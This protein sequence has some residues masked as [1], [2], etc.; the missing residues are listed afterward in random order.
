L[1]PENLG[2]SMFSWFVGCVGLRVEII[3]ERFQINLSIVL[4]RAKVNMKG[5]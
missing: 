4:C 2:L 1:S 5:S 3:G